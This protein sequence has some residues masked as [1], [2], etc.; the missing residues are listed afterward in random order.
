[1]AN[2]ITTAI[3]IVIIGIEIIVLVL[4]INDNVEKTIFLFEKDRKTYLIEHEK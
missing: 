3:T 2:I 4:V 1:M